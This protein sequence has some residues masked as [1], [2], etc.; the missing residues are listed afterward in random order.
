MER[1]QSTSVALGVATAASYSDHLQMLAV[2]TEAQEQ[3]RACQLEVAQGFC[4]PCMCHCYRHV[5]N[6]T[7]T[8][9]ACGE[10]SLDLICCNQKRGER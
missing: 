2:E 10:M 6:H 8:G 3:N 9:F 7:V 4:H 1:P 5:H